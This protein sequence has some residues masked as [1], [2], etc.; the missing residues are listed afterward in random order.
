MDPEAVP[1]LPPAPAALPIDPEACIRAGAEWVVALFLS[2]PNELLSHPEVVAA[3]KK[4]FPELPTRRC[5]AIGRAAIK[6]LLENPPENGCLLRIGTG[7]QLRWKLL[8]IL[9]M[10]SE[11][12]IVPSSPSAERK[13]SPSPIQPVRSPARAVTPAPRVNQAAVSPTLGTRSPKIRPK[14]DQISSE[15]DPASV[16]REV[17]RNFSGKKSAKTIYDTVRKQY[18]LL[19]LEDFWKAFH[20]QAKDYGV[21]REEQWVAGTK[22]VYFVRNKTGTAVN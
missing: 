19:N 14:K 8:P 12:P 7:R 5:N 18:P 13:V 17:L 21:T 3:L 22:K 11:V 20:A 16:T 15:L 9:P 1:V 6:A 10:T 4:A 2:R